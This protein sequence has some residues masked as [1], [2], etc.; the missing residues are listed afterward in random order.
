MNKITTFIYL[1]ILIFGLPTLLVAQ[2]QDIIITYEKSNDNSITFNYEKKVPGSYTISVK[3]NS[4]QNALPSDYEGVVK[5]NSGMLFKIRPMRADE[6]II[7]SYSY[8]YVR[9]DM[10][11]KPD[12]AFVYVL[13]FKKGKREK[14]L[15]LSFIGKTYF[16]DS[17]PINW[18]AFRFSFKTPDTACAIRKGIVIKIEDKYKAD[19]SISINYTSKQNTITIEHEDGTVAFYAGF[20]GNGI[21]VKEGDIVYPQTNLGILSQYDVS[22]NYNLSVQLYYMTKMK[23]EDYL[24]KSKGQILG[25][26]AH[27]QTYINPIFF[28]TEGKIRLISSKGYEADIN[29]EVLTKEFTKKELKNF[30]KTI[31]K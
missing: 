2:S 21:F 17:E 8:T 13:P 14:A 4:L 25:K 3:F 11:A 18:K 28:T 27:L 20:L 1:L 23:A 5:N 30:K 19:T 10:K 24:E 22:K 9:G 26:N 16:K 12:T 31:V 15:E 7:F 6:G 29:E